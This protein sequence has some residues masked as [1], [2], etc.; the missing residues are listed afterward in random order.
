[1]VRLLAAGL[2]LVALGLALL[3]RSGRGIVR[4]F[5]GPSRT[6][7]LTDRSACAVVD[8]VRAE[9]AGLYLLGLDTHVGLLRVR[10]RAVDF[11]H[12][13]GSWPRAVVCEPALTSPSLR[14]RVH[15]WGPLLTDATVDSWLSGEALPTA[16]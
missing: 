16:D 3:V 6:V 13:A 15:V 11:C 4:T 5:A 14:S 1:M 2:L 10:G 9:G 8:V 12:A 7:W